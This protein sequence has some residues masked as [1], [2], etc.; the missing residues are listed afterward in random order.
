M[1]AGLGATRS[2]VCASRLCQGRLNTPASTESVV[3]GVAPEP[4]TPSPVGERQA[5][6][7]VNKPA[8]LTSIAQLFAARRPSNIAGLIV[9]VVVDPVETVSSGRTLT[10]ISKECGEVRPALA[11]RN[12]ATSIK[13][14]G[15]SLSIQTSGPHTYPGRVFNR[16]VHTVRR[17]NSGAAAGFGVARHK[18]EGLYGGLMATIAFADPSPIQRAIYNNQAAEAVAERNRVRSHPQII[19]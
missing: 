19:R 10:D 7:P 11:D 12:A 6:P 4:N 15:R 5:F 8:I 3:Q 17:A 9:A 18:I 1:S 13:G 16:S 2:K 14:I